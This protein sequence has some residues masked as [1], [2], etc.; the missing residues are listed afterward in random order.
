MEM[1]V[2]EQMSLANKSQ[3]ETASFKMQLQVTSDSL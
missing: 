1:M 2:R 3:A